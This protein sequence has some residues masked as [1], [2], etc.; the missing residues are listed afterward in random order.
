MLEFLYMGG[1]DLERAIL[2]LIPEPWEKA[3]DIDMDKKAFYKYNSTII[4]PWDGPASIV[5]T[6]GDKSWCCF[7]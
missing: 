3:E 5:F 6:D 1:R 2:M 7:R 4:E